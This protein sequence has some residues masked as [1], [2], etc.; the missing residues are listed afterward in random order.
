MFLMII[1]IIYNLDLTEEFNFVRHCGQ[2][3][4]NFGNC[5]LFI[6]PFTSGIAQVK[7]GKECLKS[8]VRQAAAL[9]GFTILAFHQV[10]SYFLQSYV[11]SYGTGYG[12]C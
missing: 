12:L 4:R 11:F 7:N 8:R 9:F 10:K 3:K 6:L 2:E 5:G 1:L